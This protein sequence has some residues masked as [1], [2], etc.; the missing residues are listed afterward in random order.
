MGYNEKTVRKFIDMGKKTN[1]RLV[2]MPL[3]K[4]FIKNT[5]SKIADVKNAEFKC[6]RASTINAGA[7]LSNFVDKELDWIHLD[8]A[9]PTLWVRK[10]K[11][12][13]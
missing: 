2:E 1:D 9:G 7:F 6:D 4:E 11:D 12:M 13:V 3:Y 5:E 8:V 10:Q